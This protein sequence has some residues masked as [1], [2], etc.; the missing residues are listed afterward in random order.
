VRMGALNN[1]SIGNYSNTGGYMSFYAPGG[2]DMD[3]DS[4]EVY[5]YDASPI[6][7]YDANTYF[8]NT[9]Y[10]PANH[11][12]AVNFVPVADGIQTDAAITGTAEMYN[13]GTFVTADSSIGMHKIFEAPQDNVSYV[14]EGWEIYSYDGASHTGVHIGE[15]ADVD[16]PS[17]TNVNDEA[18]VV[19]NLGTEVGFVINGQDDGGSCTPNNLRKYYHALLGHYFTSEYD[20]NPDVNHQTIDGGLAAAPAALMTTGY[21]FIADSVWKYLN[22]NGSFDALNPGEDLRTLLSFGTFD[23]VPGDTLVIWTM[24]G[25]QIDGS[26]VGAGGLYDDALA[27][28]LYNRVTYCCSCCGTYTGGY[29][30]NTNCDVD[31][32]RNLADITK[33]IDHVYISKDDLCCNENGNVDGDVQGKRNLADITKLIDFVYISKVEVPPCL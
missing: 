13:T 3:C 11:D 32:K 23:I 29:P 16:V 28:Y 30:G 4:Q 5:L 17:A 21:E 22:Q 10:D 8:W 2:I 18:T 27:W 7:M 25:S 14:V 33:L 31:G 26:P 15:W 1:G 6:I 9:Y 20:S 19:S 12:P 24:H